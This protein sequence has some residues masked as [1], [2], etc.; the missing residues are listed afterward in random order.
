M[1]EGCDCGSA[2]PEKL[3]TLP[4]AAFQG[5]LLGKDMKQLDSL[6]KEANPLLK[7]GHQCALIWWFN[8]KFSSNNL[9]SQRQIQTLRKILLPP[10]L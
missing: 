7:H 6:R 2:G 1:E 8:Q 5:R 4:N 3:I 10:P 9:D